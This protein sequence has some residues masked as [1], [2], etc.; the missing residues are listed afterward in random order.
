M[1]DETR[2]L[3]SAVSGTAMTTISSV[4]FS[5]GVVCIAV[6]EAAGGAPVATAYGFT[7]GLVGLYG[8]SRVA[9]QFSDGLFRSVYERLGWTP[10]SDWHSELKARVKTDEVPAFDGGEEV[11]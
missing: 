4:F 10:D 6:S 3:V 11:E 2:Y 9:A 8:M 5:A 7:L 1:D